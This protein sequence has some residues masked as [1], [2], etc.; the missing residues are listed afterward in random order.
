M[1]KLSCAVFLTF[2]VVIQTAAQTGPGSQPTVWAA[3][4]DAAAFEKFVND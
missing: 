1:S 2:L 4:P 3:K